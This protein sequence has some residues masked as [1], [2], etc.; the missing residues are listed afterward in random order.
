MPRISDG[1]VKALIGSGCDSA[2]DMYKLMRR[3]DNR[4][5]KRYDALGFLVTQ[6][7]SCKI[8]PLTIDQH[9][10]CKRCF[11][12]VLAVHASKKTTFPAYSF[13]VERCLLAMNRRDLIPYINLLKCK[14]RRKYYDHT[15]GFIFRNRDTKWVSCR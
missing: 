15:Y 9:A 5:F 12:Q 6:L 13:L 14:R 11:Q 2:V 4:R 8:Q 3:S 1:L 10:W 7:T